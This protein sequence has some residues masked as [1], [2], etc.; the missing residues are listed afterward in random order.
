MASIRLLSLGLLIVLHGSL[1]AQPKIAPPDKAATPIAGT[2]V[3]VGGG[4][5]PDSV[6]NAFVKAAGGMKADLVVIPTAS[7]SADKETAEK[8][9]EL[10]QKRGIGSVKILHTRSREKANDAAFVKPLMQATAIWLGGGDQKR[11]T[12]AY[13]NTLVEKEM[14]ALLKRNGVIGGTSA[15]AAVMSR[16]MI[17]GGTVPAN[18]DE[19]FGF[20]P[21]CVIDQHFL[22][23]NRLDRLLDVLHRNPA[24]YGL[25]LDEGTAAIVQ[26]KQITIVG[27]SMALLAQRSP[28]DRPASIRVM[29]SGDKA[30]LVEASKAALQRSAK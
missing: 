8:T 1:H 4:K 22:K 13:K 25:G 10:W 18:L 21:N 17:T 16:L 14:F 6:I 15:G 24:W 27:D 7:V 23:R 5:M 11:I 9:I 29:H 2:L 20:L 3:I 26:G 30:D 12:E 28:A 19:G